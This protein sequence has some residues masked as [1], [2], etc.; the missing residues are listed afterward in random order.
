MGWLEEYSHGPVSERT[1][2]C[3][4]C[5]LTWEAEGHEEYGWWWPEQDDDALCPECGLE[6][7]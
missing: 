1:L 5:E 7:E 4:R 6:G 3:S 2:R